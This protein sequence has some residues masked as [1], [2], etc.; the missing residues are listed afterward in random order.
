MQL[1]QADFLEA[2]RDNKKCACASCQGAGKTAAV[3]WAILWFS[4][5][6]P[7]SKVICTAPGKDLLEGVLW[8]ELYKW[9]THSNKLS[10]I[11]EWTATKIVHKGRD[12]FGKPYAP[13][14]FILA[15]TT[16]A[17]YSDRRRGQAGRG[18]GRVP[19]GPPPV[20]H[21]RGLRHPA[22]ALPD[23]RGHADRLREQD[24]RHRKPGPHGRPVLRHL[25]RRQRLEAVEA[26]QRERAAERHLH[27]P[28]RPGEAGERHLRLADRGPEGR[29]RLHPRAGNE[30][31]RSAGAKAGALPGEAL[32]GHRVHRL[33][34]RRGAAPEVRQSR[35]TT[36]CRSV[37]TAPASATTRWSSCPARLEDHAHDHPREERGERDHRT[38]R[39]D[40]LGGGARDAAAARHSTGPNRRR[41]RSSR[42]RRRSPWSSTRR[43]RAAAAASAT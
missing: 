31:L 38:D 22:G 26:V 17:H 35:W 4:A 41:S 37:S 12:E 2:I 5:T 21:R 1:W 33:G 20:R 27:R 18:S 3:A 16:T 23:G 14:W 13:N 8:A 40:A 30:P 25:Q 6:R 34:D 11:F 7:K 10:Q 24:R 15:R 19:R 43:T 28:G 9:I 39:D 29:P 42:P 32:H 36:R